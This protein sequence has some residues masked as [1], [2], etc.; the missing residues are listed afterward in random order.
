MRT[1]AVSVFVGIMMTATSANAVL[2]PDVEKAREMNAIID[3]VTKEVPSHPVTR[4]IYRKRDQYMIIV[5]PCSIR[6]TII[7]KRQRAGMVGPRQFDV[8][9]SS[10][11]C[12]N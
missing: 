7:T 9:L 12:D 10:K 4:I 8:K 3:A 1:E 5:G 6:A 11:R 2:A